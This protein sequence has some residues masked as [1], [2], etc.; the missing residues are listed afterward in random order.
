MMDKRQY[1]LKYK[2]N[3]NVHTN[4]KNHNN[5]I[6]KQSLVHDSSQWNRN[7]VQ[8]IIIPKHAYCE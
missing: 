4:K 6:N 2:K 8:A 7:F 1:N 3:K 5:Q